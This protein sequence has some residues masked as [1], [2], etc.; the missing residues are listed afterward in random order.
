MSRSPV[1]RMLSQ[2]IK[3]DD[4]DFNGGEMRLRP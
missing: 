2:I 4:L 3:S 1:L